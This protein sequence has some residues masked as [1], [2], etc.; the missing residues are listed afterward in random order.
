MKFSLL[1]PEL[2]LFSGAI[3]IL[4]LDVFFNKKNQYFVFFS[5][6][7][8][9]II[10]GLAVYFAVKS[11]GAP[12]TSFNNM[13]N[14]TPIVAISKSF[15]ILLLTMVVLISIRYSFTLEKYS[16][17]FFALLMIASVGGL[18]MIS[19]N[20]LL[21]FYLGLELQALSLYLLAA[22]NIKSPR[23]S[24]AGIK[25]FILGSLASGI[26]LYGISMVYG[27]CGSTN[28]TQI[29]EFVA[30]L[31]PEEVPLGLIFGLVMVIT[32]MF[33]KISAAPF[34]F[35]APDVYQ[36]SP[37]IVMGFFG[38]VVKFST[39]MALIILSLNTPWQVVAKIMLLVAM[40]SIAVGSIGAVAQHNLKRLLAFSS[41]S[42][43]GFILLA[44]IGLDK[45]IVDNAIFYLFVYSIVSIGVFSFLTIMRT[46]KEHENDATDDKTF[47]ISSLAGLS[48]NHPIMAF[49]ITILMLSSAGIPPLAGFFAKF[50]VLKTAIM[51]GMLP[52]AVIAIILSV[53]SAFYYLRIIKIM[54]FDEPSPN[55]LL[56]DYG[57][58][59]LVTIIC[60]LIN[61][62]LIFVLSTL[63]SS[64]NNFLN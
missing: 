51:V 8:T 24:E 2:I 11:F 58:A 28:F 33:F 61:I 5:H 26:L 14:S 50:Y 49:C 21:I 48:Q 36:G 34:H 64:L 27:Y 40:V 13:I 38:T 6:L 22:F 62:F 55:L 18:L 46:P 12:E 10:C 3:L 52:Y 59:R 23:S 47:A 30:K 25:Y 9:L 56:E 37:T 31:K 63:M 20:D 53:I 45:Q 57:N 44:L 17:E 54:Y 1:I 41:I 7:F 43:V 39:M 32:A 16:S 35:W 29:N 42:H 60:A 4:M 19:A 15:M